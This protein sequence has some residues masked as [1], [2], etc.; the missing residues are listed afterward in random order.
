METTNLGKIKD[1]LED[2]A[3]HETL[4]RVCAKLRA[5]SSAFSG[6][7]GQASIMGSDIFGYWII[8]EELCD[9][10]ETLMQDG[11]DNFYQGCTL[12]GPCKQKGGSHGNE[13]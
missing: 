12:Y 6:F 9:Q 1:W 5:I 7:D 4:S 8:H 13:T 2:S 11:G 10:L 3:D